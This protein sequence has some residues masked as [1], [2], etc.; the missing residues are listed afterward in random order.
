MDTNIRKTLIKV[1]GEFPEIKLAVLF[2]SLARGTQRDDSDV[3][4]AV[5]SERPLP[6]ER[7]L[8]LL[9]AL[10]ISLGRPVDL[11]DLKTAGY[12]VMKQAL[13]HGEIVLCTD[14]SVLA[15]VGKRLVFEREDFAPYV[16]RTLRER[17]RAWI[18]M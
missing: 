8:R 11:V 6:S 7:R 9:E 16:R 14:R 15:E 10:A 12:F 18:G 3:D 17:R 5:A 13:I 4:I 1:I 2:G